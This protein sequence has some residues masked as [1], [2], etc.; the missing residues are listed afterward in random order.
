[1]SARFPRPL[2][3]AVV[4]ALEFTR[5]ATFLIAASARLRVAVYAE[6]PPRLTLPVGAGLPSVLRTI[7][8]LMAWDSK[9]S[10]RRTKYAGC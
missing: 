8:A 3:L 5:Q 9:A 10:S 7:G 1:M 6:N 4:L 2:F